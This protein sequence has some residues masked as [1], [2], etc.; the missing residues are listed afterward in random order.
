MPEN[1]TPSLKAQ[2]SFSK[3]VWIVGGIFSLIII[4]LLLFKV[5]FSVLLLSLAG[6][7]IAVYFHGCAGILH[8]TFHWN[9]NYASSFRFLLI[10]F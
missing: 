3:K 7:L 6:I 10:Y 2:S 9:H 5:V 1:D 8:R 4:L